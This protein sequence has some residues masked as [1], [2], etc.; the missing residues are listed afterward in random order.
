MK[1]GNDNNLYDYNYKP[2]AGDAYINPAQGVQNGYGAQPQ[3]QNIANQNQYIPNQNQYIPNQNQYIPNQNVAGA[4]GVQNGYGAQPQNQNIANQNQY[5]PN[6]NQYIPNQNVAG[7]QGAQAGYGAQGM[8]NG[9]GVQGVQAGYGVPP[10]KIEDAF[11]EEDRRK[12]N[13]LCIISLCLFFG[14]P[15]LS[16]LPLA[17]QLDSGSSSVGFLASALSTIMSLGQLAAWVLMIVV[18]VK[19]R[20]STFGKIIMWIYLSI[21]AVCL[22]FIIIMMVTCAGILRDCHGM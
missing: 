21:L 22:I 18:R 20:Q 10:R 3:N 8:Q 17:G 5:I 14:I 2:E 12:A 6:Q 16:G 19:Y 4:Q 15:L 11:T 13:I 9:Y 7:V 1:E